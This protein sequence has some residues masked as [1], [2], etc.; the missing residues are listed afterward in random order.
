MGTNTPP[1]PSLSTI[2]QTGRF[3]KDPFALLQ[4]CRDE[5]GDVFLLRLLGLGE[6]VFL[7]SPQTAE[8]MFKAPE[9]CLSAGEANLKFLAFLLGTDSTITKDG[10]EHRARR[11]LLSTFLNGKEAA[12]HTALSRQITEETIARWPLH[13]EF[14]LLPHTTKITLRL[15]LAVI[16]GIRDR[17]KLDSLVGHADEFFETA[18]KS[19]LMVMP[20]LRWSLGKN[21]PWGRI[22]WL[23]RRLRD[24]LQEEIEARRQQQP[25]EPR[26]ILS[27]L[28]MAEDSRGERLSNETILDEI[29]NLVSAGQETSSRILVWAVRGILSHPEALG[30]IRRELNEIL[31]D[32]RI[33]EGD[34]PKFRYL[35]AV[36][37]EGIRYQPLG[38]FSGAR[39]AKKPFVIGGYEMPVGSL[40]AH[41][42]AEISQREDLFPRPRGFHPENFQDRSF[43]PYAW[44]PFGGGARTCLGR[45]LAL[46]H[47]KAVLATVFQHTEL[48]LCQAEIKPVAG[49]GFLQ[50]PDKGL[51]VEL[52]RRF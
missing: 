37:N 3:M 31:G 48:N 39:L 2:V 43:E 12:G 15:L 6:W 35:D 27:A 34:L 52:E 45:G 29:I 8:E 19:R 9:D 44:C 20:W 46:T 4:D 5:C 24:A 28:V 33:E 32:R 23:R 30:E 25:G 51:L 36:I 14:P 13:E 49:G 1:R 17:E 40:V 16:T 42:H 7:C 21:S 50:V 41:C 47:L 11:A 26:D 22:L 18:L 38:P 10:A